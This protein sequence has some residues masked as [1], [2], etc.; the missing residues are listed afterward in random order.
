[1]DIDIPVPMFFIR[2]ASPNKRQDG[3]TF[4]GHPNRRLKADL[5]G[6]RLKP[7]QLGIG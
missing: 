2:A 7:T 6:G 5:L 4:Q 3:L 1:M